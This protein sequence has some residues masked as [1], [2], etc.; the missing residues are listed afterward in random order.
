MVTPGLYHVHAVLGNTI[1]VLL[2]GS[3]ISIGYT[4]KFGARLNKSLSNLA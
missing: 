3:A 1:N 4:P 2:L